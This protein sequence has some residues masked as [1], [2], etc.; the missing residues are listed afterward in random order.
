MQWNVRE[1]A[2]RSKQLRWM[3]QDVPVDG[4]MCQ[5]GSCACPNGECNGVCVD[6][7][8]D[9]N[10]CGG[11][12]LTCNSAMEIC[13]GGCLTLLASGQDG[14]DAVAVDDTNVYWT[15]HGN[16][17]VMKEPIGGGTPTTLASGGAGR[18]AVDAENVYWLGAGTVM[19]VPIGGGSPITLASGQSS[20]Y[21]IAVDST[22]V[23]WTN[24]G[25]DDAWG[26]YIPGSGNIMT[27][28]IAGGTPTTLVYGADGPAGIALNAAGVYWI[29]AVGGAVLTYSL[30]DSTLTNLSPA[31]GWCIAV[32]ST[33]VYWTN[34]ENS[35][36]IDVMRL[37]LGGTE[38]T[39]A[40][41]RYPWGIAVD[42]TSVY[43]TDT[44]L[45]TVMKVPLD[46]GTATTLASGENHP[47]FV[48]VS[49]TGVYWTN[50]GDGTVMTTAK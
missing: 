35:T 17:T 19:K 47:A 38:V 29:E 1:R 45:G 39:L 30:S 48:A 31:Q 4:R 13:S 12:G 28:P 11:C 40:S 27:V 20:V 22:N 50:S 10:N 18:L 14:A 7:Q 42:S 43:W 33:S 2:D 25:T 26:D 6:E 37:V 16:G 24:F 49:A 46:G 44:S 3:Q 5:S 15:D 32:D 34:M 23:Y 21:G 9:P 41:G 36:D 8:T